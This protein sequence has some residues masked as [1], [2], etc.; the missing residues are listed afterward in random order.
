[1]ANMRLVKNNKKN[2][3][4]GVQKRSLKNHIYIGFIFRET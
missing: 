2:L 4:R 1:M 3:Q